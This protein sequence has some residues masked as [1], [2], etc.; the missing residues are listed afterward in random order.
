M[1]VLEDAKPQTKQLDIHEMRLQMAQ[2]KN[3][4]RVH[5]SD[6]THKEINFFY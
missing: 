5:Y 1:S 3:L 4:V 2:I 6:T